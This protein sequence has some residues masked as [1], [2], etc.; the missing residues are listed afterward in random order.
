[1]TENKTPS[2]R[3]FNL[4][5]RATRSLAYPNWVMLGQYD[6]DEE[7][8]RLKGGIGKFYDEFETKAQ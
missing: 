8:D 4:Y 3:M 7:R 1:M 2:Q 6:S 5:G